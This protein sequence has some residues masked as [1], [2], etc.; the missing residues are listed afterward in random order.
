MGL[1]ESQQLHSIQIYS[2]SEEF[3]PVNH[4]QSPGGTAFNLNHF[5]ELRSVAV[6]P[7][8]PANLRRSQTLRLL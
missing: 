8:S 5:S 4:E 1:S 6:I 3:R 2:R 7:L